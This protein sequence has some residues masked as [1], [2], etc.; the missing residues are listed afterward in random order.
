MVLETGIYHNKFNLVDRESNPI[1]NPSFEQVAWNLMVDLRAI[2]DRY[3][4][5]VSTLEYFPEKFQHAFE[6]FR[7]AR[8]TTAQI[9]N[10]FAWCLLAA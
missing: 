10:V 5:D 3:L 1:L 4:D 8:Q 7:S 9:S 2:L 6:A